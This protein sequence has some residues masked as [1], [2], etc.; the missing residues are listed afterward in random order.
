MTGP[1]LP[2][3]I[4]ADHP[5]YAGHFPGNPILPGVALLDEALHRLAAHEGLAL[6]AGKINSAKFPGPIRPGEPLLLYYAAKAAG[7]FHFE[8]VTGERVAA[9]GT[10]AFAATHPVDD[11]P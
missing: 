10:I 9:S 8:V 2:L 3:F 5:A 6:A 7:V 1:C 11:A 4:A